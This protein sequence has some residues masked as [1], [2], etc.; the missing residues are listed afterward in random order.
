MK[1]CSAAESDGESAVGTHRVNQDVD[2]KT[3]RIT[4]G[5][6]LHFGLLDTIPPFGGLGVMIDTPVTEVVIRTAE[7]FRSPTEHASLVESIARQIADD[8]TMDDLP[9]CCIT[10]VNSA[11]RHC[12]LGSGTQLSMAVAEGITTFQG[13]SASTTDIACRY[14]HRGRRS[15]VGSHGYFQGGMIC[16]TPTED[17]ALNPI[18]AR[19]QLPATWRVVLFRPDTQVS[20]VTGDDEAKRFAEL[21][22]ATVGQSRRLRS[23]ITEQIIPAAERQDFGN[24][25]DAVQSY[26]RLSGQLFA[27]VQ[28]GPYHGPEV[29]KFVQFLIDQG[30]SGVGQSSWGPGVFA[31]FPSESDWNAFAARLPKTRHRPIVASV[32]NQGRTLESNKMPTS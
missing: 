14:G 16:E 28:G 7:T 29:T 3:I 11:P 15:A 25:T 10:I 8:H 4:T 20:H 9:R 32:R 24:F 5:A 23:M 30:A 18:L 26:N 12:G 31:W 13:I 1:D 22:P 27:A 21:L 17:A 19:V 6:R 2:A